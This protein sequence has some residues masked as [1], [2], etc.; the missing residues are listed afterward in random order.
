M[1]ITRI[2]V[3]LAKH[4]FQIH[5]VDAKG[6]VVVRRQLARGKVRPF[7]TQLAPCVVGMESCGGAH[8]WAREIKK[9][10]L[11]EVSEQIKS[12]QN[13]AYNPTVARRTL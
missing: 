1:N 6:R 13:W 12:S 10:N 11:R 2:G 8:Y 4:V 9:L 3:D 7:F 5:G